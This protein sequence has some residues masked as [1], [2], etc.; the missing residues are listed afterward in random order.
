MEDI[1]MSEKERRHLGVL[2]HMLRQFIRL[3]L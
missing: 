1:R 2:A 3:R